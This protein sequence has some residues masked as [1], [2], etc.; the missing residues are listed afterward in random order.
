MGREIPY[1]ELV[2]GWSLELERHGNCNELIKYL[3]VAQVPLWRRPAHVPRGWVAA[4][5]RSAAT[6]VEKVS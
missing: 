5:V 2:R 6:S 3:K 4:C 1:V